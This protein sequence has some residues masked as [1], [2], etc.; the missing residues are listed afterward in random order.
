MLGWVAD[1]DYILAPEGDVHGAVT[2][3]LQAFLT[4]NRPFFAD[5]SAW[6]DAASTLAL[7]HYGGA[8]SLARDPGE[9]RYGPEGREVQ[10]TLRPGPA[11]LVRL[12]LYRNALRLLAIGV[13]VEDE[14]VTIRRAGARVRTLRT[15]A[16]EVIHRILDDGW[17]HH[18]SLV[19][20]DILPELRAV[21]RLTGIPLVEL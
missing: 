15:P 7:W 20:G 13:S 8:P 3:A 21:S 6:D 17:E 11:T 18:S 10:F 16:S 5:I 9:I 4:G 14:P 19:H 1:D 2:M 12:G